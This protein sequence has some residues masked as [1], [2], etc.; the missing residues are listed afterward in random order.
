MTSVIMHGG[1]EIGVAQLQRHRGL[2]RRIRPAPGARRSRR[3]GMRPAVGTPCVSCLGLALGGEAGDEDRALRDRI[4]LAVGGLQ[5]R[6]DQRAAG[7]RCGVAERGDVDVDARARLDEGRQVGGDDDGRDVLGAR[8]AAFAGDAEI[9]QHGADR[10][11]GEGRV[12]QA[13]A[14]ALQA[15]DQAVADQ[16]V[17]ARALQ[18]GDVLDA[19]R[20]PAGRQRAG[21]WITGTC[22]LVAAAFRSP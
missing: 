15:D 10:L 16:L 20:R 7:E 18:L 5:R 11:L 1:R 12:A 22:G 4:D 6:H 9:F 13:V 3:S 8:A 17:V 21:R 14:G 2:A 19:R